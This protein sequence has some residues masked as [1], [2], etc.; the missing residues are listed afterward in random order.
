LSGLSDRIF[1]TFHFSYNTQIG[2]YRVLIWVLPLAVVAATKRICDEL[3]REE[4]LEADRSQAKA[5]A[6]AVD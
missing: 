1:L 5:E 6:A 2:L 4:T 3:R